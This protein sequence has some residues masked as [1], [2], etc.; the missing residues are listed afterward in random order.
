LLRGRYQGSQEAHQILKPSAVMEELLDTVLTARSLVIAA[1]LLVGLAALATTILVF[2]LSRRMRRSEIETFIK[3]GGPRT[4]VSAVLWL[5]VLI[6]L[7]M[8]AA[9][10]TLLTWFVSSTAADVLRT[11][12]R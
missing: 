3:I 11:L 8:A 7:L 2:A 10:A 12:L 9:L 4:S 6:V 1:M 5:E